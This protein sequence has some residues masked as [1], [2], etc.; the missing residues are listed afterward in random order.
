MM[1]VLCR[2]SAGYLIRHP[3]QLGLAVV[4]IC[5]GVA[6][7][8]AVD[9]A[10][11]SARKAFL[12]SMATLNG[13]ATHQVIGGPGGLDERLYTELR[14]ERGFR[15]IAPIV[16][17]YVQVDGHSL[18]VLGIDI[19]AE[20]EFRDFAAPADDAGKARSAG[21]TD[22]TAVIRHFLAGD[23]G[24]WLSAP[25]AAELGLRNGSRFTVIGAGRAFTAAVIGIAD[26]GGQGALPN[27]VIADISVAQQW[28]GMSGRLS[29]IDVRLDDDSEQ[30]VDTFRAALPA[31]NEL[32]SAA[33]RTRTTLE[34]SDAFMTNLKAMSL[35][36]L[37][38]GIFLIYNS[39]AFAVLQRRD[40]IGTLRAL[41]VTRRQTFGLILGE[42]AVI[43]AGGA[44]LG[45]IAGT[46]L[47]QQLLALVTRTL[48][49]HYFVVDVTHVTFDSVSV[50]RGLL[51]GFG[52]TLVAAF[53]PALEASG[54][55]P[56]LA[57]TRSALEQK[58]RGAIPGLAV[59]GIA[60][61]L[62]GTL[63]LY[64]STTNLGAGLGALFMLILGFALCI[65]TGVRAL[66]AIL[67][68]V[69]R[70]L[71]GTAG[72]LAV[73]DV[74]RTLSRTGVAVVALAIAVSATIG[75]SIMVQSFRT[76]VGSWLRNTLQADIYVGVE[77]GAL[78]PVLLRELVAIPG[79]DYHSTTRRAWAET[80]SGRIR[81]IALDMPAGRHT[82]TVIRGTDPATAWRLFDAGPAVLVSDSYAYRH[83]VQAG[84][85][86]SITA[87]TG[88][89][90]LPV[91][92]VYQSYDAN[93]GAI[94][95]SRRTYDGLFD[96]PGVTSLG[97]YLADGR[98]AEAVMAELRAVSAGRQALIMNSNA[99]IRELSLGI[100]D[101]T[102]LITD[103]LYWLA[104]AVAIIGILGAMLGMQLERSR[105]FGI[106]RAL[107]MTPFQTGG[108]VSLQSAF[109]GLLA[110]LAA[111]PLGLLMAWILV[112]V[113]NRR[114]FG[115]QITF[116]VTSAE[117][118]TALLLAVGAALAGGLYP[119]WHAARMRPALAMRE[120]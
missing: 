115:W 12:L 38:V 74:G 73:G 52:A 55:R 117:L 22:P 37:L 72:R 30:T 16:T 18:Q 94:L 71:A 26:A 15:N 95:M 34:M 69:A 47:A 109:L 41:G 46:W 42:A 5:I 10:T 50:T 21:G 93:E 99:R 33:G 119:A 118:L 24:V 8:I 4:G 107:G 79:I 120:E 19:F 44:A 58:A 43:G 98:D 81:L 105:E 61:M 103:V 104:V 89:A 53:V 97:L 65:P 84:D 82:G 78:D 110:G 66:S 29:R 86:V 112:A 9:L 108:L 11:T 100:F 36:A 6:V 28:L 20:R 96:D 49:D 91:A 75:V 45:L 17:G 3:W 92:G 77:A 13:H 57:L 23:G 76:S 51:A 101:R 25:A 85:T 90:E 62:L 48:S 31:G 67:E 106:L 102:F 68:P 14:M 111:M 80:T 7:M 32:L 87:R 27:L 88:P 2:A 116:V 60:L 70:R 59:G 35:L 39:V 56:R 114:A 63:I 113:I 1:P 83:G 40:L 64:L 54:Y